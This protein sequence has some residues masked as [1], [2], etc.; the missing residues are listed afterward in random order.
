MKFVIQ[1]VKR[2]AVS[3]DGGVVGEIGKGLLVFLGISKTDTLDILQRYVDKLIKLRIFSD[4]NGKTNLSLLDVEGALLIVS[5]FTLYA[6]CRKGNRP[7]FIHAGSPDLADA[8]YE[9]FKLL[10]KLQVPVV[11]SGIF[12]ADM[13]VSLEN[14]GPFTIVLDSDDL[15]L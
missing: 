5:Q 7:S 13:M 15:N 1:R 6:D 2:A 4:E 14:D 3:V 12:G 8:L 9:E 11:E 10:C